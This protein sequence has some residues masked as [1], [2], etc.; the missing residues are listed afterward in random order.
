MIAFNHINSSDFGERFVKIKVKLLYQQ[1]IINDEKC[2]KFQKIFLKKFRGQI[3]NSN[4]LDIFSF[5]FK[6][7][8]RKIIIRELKKKLI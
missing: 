1:L 3:L 8:N 7:P 5:I 2:K 6:Y 4:F